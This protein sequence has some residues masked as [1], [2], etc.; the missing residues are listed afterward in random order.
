MPHEALGSARKY[1]MMD[2]IHTTSTDDDA[3]LRVLVASDDPRVRA[4]LRALVESEPSMEVVGEARTAIEVD[5][6]ARALAPSV[7]VLDL[8]LPRA[9][10]GLHLIRHLAAAQ[11]RPVIALCARGGMREAALAAGAQSF[12]EQGFAPDLLMAA[13][14]RAGGAGRN[15]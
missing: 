7:I 13:L 9:V 3:P 12:L 6:S 8:L 10:D 14:R 11:A 5:D 1:A 2:S 4:A 15:A